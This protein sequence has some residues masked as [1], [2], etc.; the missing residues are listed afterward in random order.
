MMLLLL[1]LL[2]VVAVEGER[3]EV[4]MEG[5]SLS[6]EFDAAQ[7]LGATLKRKA[8]S[9]VRT[10]ALVSGV[11]C[12]KDPDCVAQKL[13]ASMALVCAQRRF[14]DANE[15]IATRNT[16]NIASAANAARDLSLDFDG[17]KQCGAFEA[18][19]IA[20]LAEANAANWLNGELRRGLDAA[21]RA[22]TY[23][24]DA[25][26]RRTLE[27]FQ[28][29]WDSSFEG[30]EANT[31]EAVCQ[32]LTGM[33]RPEDRTH[34]G[35]LYLSHA[36][37]FETNDA[38]RK[39]ECFV[40]A[41]LETEPLDHALEIGFNAGHSAAMLLSITNASMEIYDLCEHPYTLPALT[42]LRDRFQEHDIF[43]LCGDS[44]LTLPDVLE[45]QK[46]MLEDKKQSP[47]FVFIDGGHTYETAL[48]DIRHTH[49][50][51][52]HDATVV[53]DDCS[54]DVYS[55][56]QTALSEGLVAERHKGV[57]WRGL[58]IGRII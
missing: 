16:A 7:D 37:V 19:K 47:D 22:L 38:Q 23:V 21:R 3:L 1:V 46:L 55:A 44:K 52:N 14:D 42:K 58:C 25:E 48:A 20:S 15:A 30:F 13:C 17:L 39:R 29:I 8:E 11:G 54:G 41:I 6:V 51:A 49:Q 43:F 9:F 53:V 2:L 32:E 50:R 35:G 57:C 28:G 40:S 4:A 12:D 56:W 10:H 24:D 26:G 31:Y 18:G 33:A 45:K 34:E 27:S 5:R 36:D